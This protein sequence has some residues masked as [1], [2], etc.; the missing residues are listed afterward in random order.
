MK[1]CWFCGGAIKHDDLF[2]PPYNERCVMCGRSS[3]YEREFKLM[4]KRKRDEGKYRNW[5]SY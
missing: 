1:K 2:D 4:E 5:K 3:D